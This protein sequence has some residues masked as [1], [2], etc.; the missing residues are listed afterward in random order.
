[1]HGS[2]NSAGDWIQIPS[3]AICIVRA[4]NLTVCYFDE[5]DVIAFANGCITCGFPIRKYLLHRF[6]SGI[7]SL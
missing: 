4:L 6:C 5:A 7:Q 3:P 2:D 1:M